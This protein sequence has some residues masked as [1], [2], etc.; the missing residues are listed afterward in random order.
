V[1]FSLVLFIPITFLIQRWTN[2][3]EEDIDLPKYCD[4]DL[5]RKHFMEDNSPEQLFQQKLRRTG[6]NYQI[7]NANFCDSSPVDA[8]IFVISK[9]KNA[10]SRNAIRRTWGDLTR[11][12]FVN[13]LSHLRFKLLFLIDIDESH[14]MSIKLEQSIN[15]DIVQVHLPESYI[16]STYRD[17]AI[18]HWT[19][20]YCSDALTTVKTDDDIFLN[21]FLLGHVINTIVQCNETHEPVLNC[22]ASSTS[23]KI[24]GV[25]IL[26]GKVVRRS[27]DPIREGARYIVTYDEYPCRLYPE[28]MSGFGYIVNRHARSKLLCTFLRDKEPFHLSDVYVTGIIPEYVGIERKRLGVL[29]SY[30][31]DDNCEEF[32]RKADRDAYACASSIHYN[33]HMNIFEQ[34]NANWKRVYENRNLYLRRRFNFSKNK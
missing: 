8:L 29:I 31:S 9:S 23:A 12:K 14:L 5:I 25:S 1:L 28:Y 20:K 33:K 32:F 10:N 2:V 11:L 6:F 4:Q 26:D 21:T 19:D 17:M 15:N 13:K 27:T 3:I 30:R 16:L 34:F 7:D 24:Y 18:L 22:D